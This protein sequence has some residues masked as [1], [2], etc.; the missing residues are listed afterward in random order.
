M[1]PRLAALAE[2]LHGLGDGE[3]VYRFG[4]RTISLVPTSLGRRIE[5]LNPERSDALDPM[6]MD[7]WGD[8]GGVVREGGGGGGGGGALGVWDGGAVGAGVG[9][10]CAPGFAGAAAS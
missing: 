2:R 1:A 4:G 3:W 10:G 5:T 6:P 7:D 8:G 9:G